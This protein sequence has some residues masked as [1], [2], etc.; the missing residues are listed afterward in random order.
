M[1]VKIHCLVFLDFPVT[2]HSDI[3]SS[4][5]NR[6]AMDYL[7]YRGIATSYFISYLPTGNSLYEKTNQH[8]RSLSK[9]RWEDVLQEDRKVYF[10][11]DRVCLAENG[12]PHE[13]IF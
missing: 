3:G 6:E 4:F 1:L 12:T 5:L 13:R 10:A 2:V 8:D 11:F 7:F 9:E